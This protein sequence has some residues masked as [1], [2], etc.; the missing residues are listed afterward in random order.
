MRT[1]LGRLVT[2]WLAVAVLL[3]A[4]S[5]TTVA[6]AQTSDPMFRSWEWVDEPHS[7]RATALAGSMAA[8]ASDGSTALIFPAGL[9]LVSE[10][11]L[12]VSARWTTDGS[13]NAD[14]VRAGW[15]PGEVA[16]ASPLGLRWGWGAYARDVRH[17]TYELGS[18]LL[19]DGSSDAGSMEVET[20]EVG[21]GVGYALSPSLR[22]GARVGWARTELSGRSITTGAAGAT[23]DATVQGEDGDLRVGV[24]MIFAPEERFQLG[25]H[26]D[27]R[28]SWGGRATCPEDEVGYRLIA[29]SRFALGLLYR[30][31]TFVEIMAQGDYVKWSEVHKSLGCCGEAAPSTNF[32]RGD[33]YELRL[34]SE[35]RPEFGNFGVWQRVAL[36]FG[37][38]FRT[39]GL[40]E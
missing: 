14:T 10:T 25:I 1:A 36:R 21:V 9:S 22:I 35:L 19:P 5:A 18:A 11:D 40:L 31:S 6:Q 20:R 3:S 2:P 33:G 7:A 8:Q 30:P 4:V 26:Y 24:G 12:R 28:G 15:A 17:V 29:P 39:R 13:H 23:R 34:G 38:H 16:L 37:V 32:A 27:S